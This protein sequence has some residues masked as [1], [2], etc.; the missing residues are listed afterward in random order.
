MN[1][2]GVSGTKVSSTVSHMGRSVRETFTVWRGQQSKAVED[3]LEL[4][5]A[6]S[7]LS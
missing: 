4:T 3:Y 2:Y 7:I 5:D 1:G 6:V